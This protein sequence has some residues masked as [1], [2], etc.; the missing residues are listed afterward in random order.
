M[1]HFY[2]ER[3]FDKIL[4]LCQNDFQLVKKTNKFILSIKAECLILY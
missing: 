2:R 3:Y 1:I 4:N